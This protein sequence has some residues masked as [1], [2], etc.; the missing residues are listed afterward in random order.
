M[1]D[2]PDKLVEVNA[3]LDRFATLIEENAQQL[4]EDKAEFNRQLAE[5]RKEAREEA[6]R[7]REE[8]KRLREEAER[9]RA[10]DLANDKKRQAE[11]ERQRAED[12]AKDE[13]RQAEWEKR[14]ANMYNQ[15]GGQGNSIGDITEA[16]TV[17]DDIIDLVNEFEGIDVGY[18]FF[19]TRH[20]YPAKNSK[21]KTIRKHYEVD[22]LAYGETVAIVIEAKTKLTSEHITNLIKKLANFKLAYPDHAEKRLYGAIA[23]IRADDEALSLAEHHGLFLLKASPPDVELANNEN[24]RPTVVG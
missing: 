10:E 8:A 16:I 15:V 7:Q 21:G 2:K 23:F 20:K 3:T 24:F 13:K 14:F 19:N 1:S 18:F 11:L 22:G 17:S 4:R 5:A 9:Q 12:Q 6:K